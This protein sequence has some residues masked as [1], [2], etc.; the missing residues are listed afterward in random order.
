MMVM[1][2]EHPMLPVPAQVT[3]DV[4]TKHEN[5]YYLSNYQSIMPDEETY[6]ISITLNGIEI[7]T[8]GI[9]VTIMH[10][11]GI[12]LFSTTFAPE[13]EVL[14]TYHIDGLRVVDANDSPQE[15]VNYFGPAAR[16]RTESTVPINLVLIPEHTNGRVVLKWAQSVTAGQQYYYRVEATDAY[17]NFSELSLED[18]VF[19]HEGLAYEGYLVERSYN[20]TDW[21]IV[22]SQGAEEYV[23]YGIDRDAPNPPLNVESLVTLNNGQSTAD[24]QVTWQEGSLGQ[25]AV[26]PMYRVRSVSALGGVSLPSEV[27]G[28]VYLISTIDRYVIRRKINDGSIPTY[29]GP[30][31]IT[32]GVTDHLTLQIT[33]LA[34]VHMTDYIYGVYAIDK[35]GNV[36]MAATTIASIGDATI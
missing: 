21:G 28:P 24:V 13:D 10:E 18:S 15:G 26:S 14:A 23:E 32:V 35:A 9:S 29:D 25:A 5:G 17:G 27:V 2:V 36:S 12:F 3:N 7:S 20:G 31:A 11:E 16:D 6:P 1:E 19:L 8:L 4:L 22:S 33:D 34:V 30:D